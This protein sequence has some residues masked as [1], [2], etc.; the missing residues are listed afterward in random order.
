MLEALATNH[1]VAITHI[2]DDAT[3]PRMSNEHTYIIYI[4]TCVYIYIGSVYTCMYIYIHVCIHVLSSSVVWDWV[5]NLKRVHGPAEQVFNKTTAL[6]RLHSSA[7]HLLWDSHWDCLHNSNSLSPLHD[8][9]EQVFNKTT[10]LRR[11]HSSASYIYI[12]IYIYVDIYIYNAI[13]RY[14][15]A[16]GLL[17][18]AQGPLMLTFVF[19]AFSLLMALRPLPIYTWVF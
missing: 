1:P 12:Y 10:A 9:A 3:D 17:A 2:A 16:V 5:S 14:M 7:S 6:R 8:P 15:S 11:L 19:Y 18:T 13:V 4:Y